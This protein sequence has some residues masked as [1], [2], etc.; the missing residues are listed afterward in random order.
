MLTRVKGGRVI[1][2]A[3]GRDGIGDIW[4]R[5]GRIVD[6]PADSRP[7]ETYDAAGKIVMAGAI[8]IH[9]HI[10]GGN[11]NTARLL[12]PEHHRSVD[13][14][15]P[16]QTPLSQRR[17]VDLRDRLPL[18]RDGLHHRR[19]AG[20]RAASRA[21][22]ASRARRHSDHRQ[23]DLVGARQRRF[24]AR[25]DARGSERGA[26]FA[27]TSPGRLQHR[28]RSASRSSMPAAR[29]PSRP[30]CAHSR[31]DDVVPCYGVTSRAIVK[32]LQHAVHELGVPHPLHVHCNNLGLPGNAE[33][34]L[35]TIAA[36]EGLPLHLAHLQFY[37]YG[38][39][40]ERGF[41]SAAARLAEAVNAAQERDHRCR[42]GDVRPDRHDLLRR[43]APVQRARSG[44]AEEMGDLRRRR[45]TAAA[46]CRTT[47]ARRFLQCRAMGDRPGAVPADRRSLRACSS[48]PTIRTAR[49]SRPIR[50]SS[51][52]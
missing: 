33:T 3:N 51:R 26:R 9:S 10:A 22:R 31:F 37:G 36:A 44:A 14:R 1:D 24:P 38:K 12:L 28:A 15:R 46:S 16:A 50:R 41:S 23:G 2:P 5:D 25:P 11:V 27:T 52:C 42:P 8:D 18:C 4:I 34:A 13:A 47:T 17:L 29:R 39:E 45:R 19:R 43:A 48:P 49:R 40:G 32:A 6:A 20:G 30:T 7:D 21:A 35:A